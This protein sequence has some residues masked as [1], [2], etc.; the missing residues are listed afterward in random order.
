MRG[1][2]GKSPCSRTRTALRNNTAFGQDSGSFHY[3]SSCGGRV[4]PR[5]GMGTQ[6]LARFAVGGLRHVTDGNS[7]IV[8]RSS[9]PDLDQ[10]RGVVWF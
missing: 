6:N 9:R 10:V 8:T 2:S 7:W 3:G 5:R 4:G 1:P